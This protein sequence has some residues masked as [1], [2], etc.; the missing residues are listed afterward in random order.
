M[1]VILRELT[2]DDWRA[3]RELRL[4]ALRTERGLFFVAYEDEV[5]RPESAWIA[6]ATGDEKHQV[7]GFFDDG[8]LV[9]ISGVF[10]DSED[11]SGGV[12]RLGMSYILPEYRR[13]GLGLRLYEARLAWARARPRFVRA[14]VSHRRSNEA[15]RR[16]IARFG[17]R[18]VSDQPHTWHDGVVEDDVN[19]ELLLRTAGG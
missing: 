5:E 2:V 18:W 13:R 15:T 1:A 14:T 12:A 9:G 16:A 11:P 3:L 10:T 6:L 4:H 17:F 8:R 7:F 19:Y